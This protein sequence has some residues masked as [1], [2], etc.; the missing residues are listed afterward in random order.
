MERNSSVEAFLYRKIWPENSKNDVLLTKCFKMMILMVQ[1]MHSSSGV[2]NVFV[3]SL[4]E[5]ILPQDLSRKKPGHFI[6]GD[7]F[8]YSVY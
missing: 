5:E 7:F 3:Y 1:M 6:I 8:E 4:Q 2:F